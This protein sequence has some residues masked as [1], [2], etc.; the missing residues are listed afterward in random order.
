M[1]KSSYACSWATCPRRKLPQTSRFALVSHV[2]SHTGEKPFICKVPECDKSFTRSDAL[3]KH[4][5]TH[6]G[7][8]AN[9]PGHAGR[10]AGGG[11]KRKRTPGTETP[12]PPP[13]VAA[14]EG[15]PDDITV[16][17]MEVDEGDESDTSPPSPL[18]AY[19]AAAVDPETGLI[20]GRTPAVVKYILIKARHT[21][22]L[23]EHEALLEGL[24]VAKSDCVRA[25]QEKDSMVDTL[26][27]R[28]GVRS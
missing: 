20:H 24:R 8:E 4:A 16:P 9:P 27:E 3:S 22:A 11:R 17:R 10:G 26:M 23:E 25:Q 6:H 14:K 13:P 1:H 21:H 12:P 18:P 2:R 5:R 15:S 19:L 7:V 28:M